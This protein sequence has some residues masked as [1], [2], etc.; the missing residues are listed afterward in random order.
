MAFGINVSNINGE[1]QIDGDLATV[2]FVFSG[3][4]G[5]TNVVNGNL[6]LSS[7]GLITFPRQINNPMIFA[8]S[9]TD[10]EFALASV[11]SSSF[12]YM[13]RGNFEYRVYESGGILQPNGTHGMLVYDANGTLIFDSNA[14]YP[15]I[16]QI[17]QCFSPSVLEYL[18]STGMW[19]A[20][21]GWVT[22]PY[23]AVATDGGY[24]F[25]LANVFSEAHFIIGASG[26]SVDV[27]ACKFTSST[28]LQVAVRNVS[29][30]GSFSRPGMF[31]VV[32]PSIRHFMLVR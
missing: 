31:Y 15:I 21:T 8:R 7:T 2:S 11:S 17:T 22:Y 12:Y 26:Q 32:G 24:P 18:T 14:R 1:T 23:N 20:Q 6:S 4:S 13:S 25:V 9:T 3:V 16:K 28:T 19:T 5:P 27:L 29:V 30:L 10:S